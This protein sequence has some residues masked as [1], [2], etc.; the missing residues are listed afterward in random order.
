MIGSL[1]TLKSHLEENH[2]HDFKSLKEVIN[3]QNSYSTFRQQLITNHE[4]LIE[5][6]KDTLN[7][8]LQQLDITIAAQKQ[9]TELILLSE[10][11]AL[12]QLLNFVTDD[13]SSN[14]FQK[15][16]KNFIQ[17]N[18]K[19]QLI[20]KERNFDIEVTKSIR[21]H[22]KIQQ[23]KRKRYQ[24]ITSQFNIAVKESAQTA[25]WEIERKKSV[26]DHSN[27]YIYGALGEQKVVKTLESLSDEHFLIN[28]FSIS[29]SNAI[30]NRQEDDYIKSIQIDHLLV[31][32]SGIFLIETKNWSEKS[33]KNLSLR[34][35]V[36]QIKR[37]N[38]ALYIL[39][40]NEISNFHLRLTDHHWGDRKIT[41]KNL[42]VFT[43]TKPKEEFQY[44]KVLTLN[45]LLSYINYFKPIFST[46][47]TQRIAE[48]LIEMNN[49]K[50]I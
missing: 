20:Y 42:I 28:D 40:K 9:Q 45:E 10:I 46:I 21:H 1:S 15:L 6:E 26:I 44:V 49:Q 25:L 2:I 19:R 29:F 3:F 31:A 39:L 12:K 22:V 5:Q 33:L 18:Y 14:L 35:P 34:S 23:V 43:N 38:F 41:V 4:T 17:W 36:S 50:T 16:R 32:P 27:S 37:S 48:L 30:Y 47:E 8:D 11:D 24:F 13:G 7:T